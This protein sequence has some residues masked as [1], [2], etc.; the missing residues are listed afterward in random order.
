MSE[1]RTFQ[2]AVTEGDPGLVGVD[3]SGNDPEF[4]VDYRSRITNEEADIQFMDFLLA[5]LTT[6][7]DN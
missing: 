6:E 2:Q 3:P 5:E 4:G 7:G 1:R